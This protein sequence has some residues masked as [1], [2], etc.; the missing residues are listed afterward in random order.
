MSEQHKRKLNHFIQLQF[1]RNLNCKEGNCCIVCHS[2]IPTQGSFYPSGLNMESLNCSVYKNNS[3]QVKK[4]TSG[5]H[6]SLDDKAAFFWSK[7]SVNHKPIIH[8]ACRRTQIPTKGQSI[9]AGTGTVRPSL[10]CQRAAEDICSTS[11]MKQLKTP[12]TSDTDASQTKTWNRPLPSPAH[13][14]LEYRLNKSLWDG[15]ILLIIFSGE[16]KP[17]LLNM[18]MAGL[19]SGKSLFF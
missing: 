10:C 12:Q 11:N 8:Q 4:K 6:S 19:I 2:E 3:V 16:K 18:T 5:A 15:K 17:G 9:S 7:S 1:K 14:D 13:K